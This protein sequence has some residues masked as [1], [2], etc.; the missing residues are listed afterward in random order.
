MKTET[1]KDQGYL[2]IKINK[3]GICGLMRF[4]FTT[5]LCYGLNEHGYK[6]RYCFESLADAK[7]ALDK[8]DGSEHPTG[9]WIKH[10]GAGKEDFSNPNKTDH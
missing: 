7:E 1:I 2:N 3:A 6:G 5:G 10:K 9:D 8:W 4:I